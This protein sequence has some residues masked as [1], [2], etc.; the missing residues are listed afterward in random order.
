M[1][2]RILLADDHQIVR[3]GLRGM[4]EKHPEFT[5]VGE[6]SNGRQAVELAL[7]LHPAVVI[8]DITMP[9]LNGVE[10]ARLIMAADMGTRIIALSMHSNQRLMHEIIKAGATGYLLKESAVAELVDA[11][12]TVMAGNSYLSPKVTESVLDGFVRRQPPGE[13][14]AFSALSGREREVLQLIAEGRT[15]KEMA[16]RLIVSVKTI[17]AHRA[18]IMDKLGIDS[19]AGLTKFAI[20]EGLTS[21]EPRR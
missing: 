4:L 12:R 10:A 8:M 6:A 1:S 7:Q 15:T 3:E 5:V 2:V 21:P 14:T 17:E 19:I 20:C 13:G 18:R 9:E 11:I 16:A